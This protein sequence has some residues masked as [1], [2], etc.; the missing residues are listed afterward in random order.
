MGISICKFVEYK[1]ESLPDQLIW[2]SIAHKYQRCDSFDVK[3]WRSDIPEIHTDKFWKKRFY[4]DFDLEKFEMV[5]EIIE[6]GYIADYL[7][8][9]APCLWRQAYI[10]YYAEERNI[11]EKGPFGRMISF[12]DIIKYFHQ[13]S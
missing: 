2:D 12:G 3:F 8:S 11:G 7:C 5:N 4:H 9:R 1:Q 13:I 6:G 10:Y